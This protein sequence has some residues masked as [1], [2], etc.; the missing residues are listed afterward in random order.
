MKILDR[1]YKEQEGERI[2]KPD[3]PYEKFISIKLGLMVSMPLLRLLQYGKIKIHPSV[4][5]VLNLLFCVAAGLAFAS[6]YLFDGAV[7]F[8]LALVMDLIDGPYARLTGRYTDAVKRNDYICDRLGKFVCFIGLWYS[9][10]Y[11]NGFPGIG[12]LFIFAYYLLEV[13]ATEMLPDRFRDNYRITF[14]V[15][16]VSFIIFVV[17][18]AL[19]MVSFFF[20]LAV[21]LLGVLYIFKSIKKGMI[22]RF[23][24]GKLG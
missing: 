23:I 10:Y 13:Y 11:L 4:F 6:G 19:N 9:Q 12:G 17:G 18:P 2:F 15:W 3:A 21:V 16:E 24:N 14:T 8:Y 7:C 1:I 22:E 20:P 5:S